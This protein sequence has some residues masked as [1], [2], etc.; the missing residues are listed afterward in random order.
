MALSLI[1]SGLFRLLDRD[2]DQLVCDE[3]KDARD[4]DGNLTTASVSAAMDKLYDRTVGQTLSA[5]DSVGFFT[6]AD[7]KTGTVTDIVEQDM[8]DQ[9][10]AAIN[11]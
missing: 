7:A 6:I 4:E 11:S 3:F 5:L 2:R 8:A 9:W 10:F 1:D